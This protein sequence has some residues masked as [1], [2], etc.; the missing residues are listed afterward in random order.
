MKIQS[1]DNLVALSWQASV[2]WI[3]ESYVVYRKKPSQPN[4]DS[5]AT[6]TDNSFIDD[7]LTNGFKYCYYMAARGVIGTNSNPIR[8]FNKSQEVCAEPIDNI[9]PC[10][11]I[12][13]S[14]ANCD[15][16]QLKITWTFDDNSCL[17]D[18]VSYIIYR[19]PSISGD[20]EILDQIND[21]NANEYIPSLSSIAGCYYVSAVDSAGNESAFTENTC[22]EYCPIYELPNV[23]TPNGD[24]VNDLYVP[25]RNPRFRYIDSVDFQ[26]YNRW[27]QL[28]F[29][30]KNPAINWDG[31]SMDSNELLSEGVYIF[32]CKVYESALIEEKEPRII[33][34][35]VTI[36]NSKDAKPTD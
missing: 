12:S 11:P 20:Y 19:S 32:I 14:S 17:S 5:I 4:F 18:I 36:L 31:K 6:T 13:S 35:T 22:V 34:G 27:D 26:V 29:Q 16:D 9:P 10:S 33:K 25:L 3:N 8:T 1:S 30:T 7:S 28:V 15:S 21:K 24:G 2:P 23:F